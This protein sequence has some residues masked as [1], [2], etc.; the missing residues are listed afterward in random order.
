MKCNLVAVEIHRRMCEDSRFGYS[1]DERWGHD[2]NTWTIGGRDYSVPAGDYDCSSSCIRAWQKA[3]EGTAYEGSLSKATYTG[4]MREVFTGS[5]L[6]DW[7]P[8]SFLAEPGD[9]YLNEGSHVAMCQTQ[10]P[11]ILSE[12]SISETG[13]TTG[14]RGDQTGWESHITDYYDYPWDGIL[15]YNGKADTDTPQPEQ[16]GD[17]V[18]YRV[19]S[20]PDGRY[21]Y[22]EM[23]DHHDTGNSGDTY[24]GEYG[25]AIRWVAVKGCRCRV[26]TTAN[27]WLP[28]VDEYN[29]NDLEYGCAGDGSVITGIEIDD[30]SIRYAA[31]II[32]GGWYSDMIGRTDTGGSG[33]TFAGDLANPIDA[34]RVCRA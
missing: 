21:W 5:G 32:G 16:T 27:G 3:L 34:I 29:I 7:E 17:Y 20:D 30:S 24:A 28:W 1:W 25:E 4:N 14:K 13:G 18:V 8:M 26:H 22:D 31:H 11:D 10:Y 12:F 15:H 33:D 2:P 6:F 9:L 19:S 23:H